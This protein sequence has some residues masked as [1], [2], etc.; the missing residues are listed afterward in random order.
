MHKRNAVLSDLYIEK[1][2]R[3]KIKGDPGYW[4]CPDKGTL[5]H[6][7]W[8][9][10]KAHDGWMSVHDCIQ[11]IIGQEVPIYMCLFLLGIHPP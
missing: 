8:N 3:A 4:M 11:R 2:L 10:P 6:A 1:D 5:I 9:C 7:L